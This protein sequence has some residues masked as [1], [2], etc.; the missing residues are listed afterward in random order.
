[1]ACI[2]TSGYLP[3]LLAWSIVRS[4]RPDIGAT[5]PQVDGHVIPAFAECDREHASGNAPRWIPCLVPV[6]GFPNRRIRPEGE[7]SL[8]AASAAG[9]FALE[10]SALRAEK[11]WEHSHQGLKSLA[12][13]VRPPGG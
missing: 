2:G 1:V 3:G 13:I 4:R 11:T 6:D 9:L 8:P 10:L 7:R 5:G 12:T